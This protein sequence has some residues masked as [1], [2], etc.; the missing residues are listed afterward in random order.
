[1]IIQM[2]LQIAAE[3]S[4]CLFSAEALTDVWNKYRN[5]KILK[6]L[7]LKL[8]LI[9]IN[10]SPHIVHWLLLPP[11]TES[12]KHFKY[13]C[14]SITPCL[15]NLPNVCKWIWGGSVL[16]HNPLP[17]L[18]NP[19]HAIMRNHWSSCRSSLRV[20]QASCTCPSLMFRHLSSLP[21][22][23]RPPRLKSHLMPV[24]HVF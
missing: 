9:H 10:L 21:A 2:S 20:F 6:N 23:D 4:N 13:G 14:N 22:S 17:H 19:K 12:V 5:D 3:S 18:S 1:M 24:D 7:S 15:W 11:I 16:M 8:A